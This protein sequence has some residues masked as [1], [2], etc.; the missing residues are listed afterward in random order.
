MDAEL[1]DYVANLKS[2]I[3][4]VRRESHDWRSAAA[5]RKSRRQV[6]AE[7]SDLIASGGDAA[8]AESWVEV[9]TNAPMRR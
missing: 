3:G 5:R 4:R 6:I 7:A 8:L 9:M 2:E 1:A